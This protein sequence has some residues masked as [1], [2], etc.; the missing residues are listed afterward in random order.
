[1]LEKASSSWERQPSIPL[2]SYYR[3]YKADRPE[4]LKKEL[5]FTSVV[6]CLP[7]AGTSDN[8]KVYSQSQTISLLE[9]GQLH[10]A[11]EELLGQGCAL[12]TFSI[13][14]KL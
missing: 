8:G 7:L 14:T 1:M 2:R 13:R 9:R 6:V 4:L 10:C 3:L 11:Q 5:F 12:S